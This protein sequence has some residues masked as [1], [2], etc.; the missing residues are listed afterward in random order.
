MNKQIDRWIDEWMD[1]GMGKWWIDA[2]VK[3]SIKEVVFED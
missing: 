1:G 3:Y 2:I